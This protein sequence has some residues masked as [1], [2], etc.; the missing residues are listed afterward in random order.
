[1]SDIKKGHV[2]KTM[3][4]KTRKTLIAYSFLT[5]PLLF[6]LCIRIFPTLYAFSL[7]FSPENRSGFTL[8]NYIHLIHDKVFWRS[9]VNTLLYVAITVPVQIAIGMI[10]ALAI[11]KVHRLQGFYRIVYFIP[12]MTSIVA[13]SW[14]WRLMYDPNTGFINEMLSWFHIPPQGWLTDPSEAL[15]SVSMMMIW[16]AMGFCMLIF[17]AGLKA[18]P[19]QFYEAA[20]IDGAGKWRMFWSITFPLLN[21]TIIFLAVT[22]V[23]TALQTFT[24][25]QN[26]TASSS[27]DAGGP[28]NSTSSIVIYMYN[29][30]FNDFNM[31][32]A[33]AITVALFILI[34]IVTFI[35]LKVLSKNFED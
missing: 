31:V 23:I 21:P 7:S 29:S 17:L 26:L 13:V 12:Y 27:G 11:N 14:V 20:Q 25:I 8:D 32:Y 22:G 15:I 28:L 5:V 4:L 6:F 9:A 34:L 19:K 24:Q 2:R 10:L 16:Q 35:Q 30:A 3:K 18:I 1:M 33:S